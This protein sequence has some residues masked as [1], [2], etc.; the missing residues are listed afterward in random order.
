MDSEFSNSGDGSTPSL[1]G[2]KGDEAIHIFPDARWIASL[3]LAMTTLNTPSPSRGLIHPS[4]AKT[5]S[6]SENRGRRECRVLQPHPQPRMRNEKAYEQSHH[7][8]AETIRHS[9]REWF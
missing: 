3:S 2:A 8:F 9:L 6:P 1:R 7:R 5:S 4:Y